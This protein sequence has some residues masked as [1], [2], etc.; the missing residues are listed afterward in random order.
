MDCTIN[1]YDYVSE[2]DMQEIMMFAV[3]F[4]SGN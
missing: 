2:L 4:G 3:R 1:T